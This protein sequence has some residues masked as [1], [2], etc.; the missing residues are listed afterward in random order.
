MALLPNLKKSTTV[1]G[2]VDYITGEIVLTDAPAS[3]SY[4]A[5]YFAM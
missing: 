1:Y 5:T 3:L 2:T 4:S